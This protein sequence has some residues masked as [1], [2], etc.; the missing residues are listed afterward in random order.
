V[1]ALEG[2]YETF[3]VGRNISWESIKEIYR[4]GL[5]RGM[6]FATISDGKGSSPMRKSRKR[7]ISPSPPWPDD[8]IRVQDGPG[9]VLRA[10]DPPY[11]LCPGPPT[12]SLLRPTDADNRRPTSV[13]RPSPGVAGTASGHLADPTSAAPS[14]GGMVEALSGEA[15]GANAHDSENPR[16]SAQAR[17]FP[18]NAETT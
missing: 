13:F 8:Q 16:L 1:L 5:K 15:I 14:G 9:R 10:G 11:F 12:A 4:L 18:S 6:K 17:C 3:T 2:C 7:V